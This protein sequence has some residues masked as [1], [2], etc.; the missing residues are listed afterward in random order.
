MITR[1]ISDQIEELYG[2]RCS[3]SFISDATDKV[4]QDIDEWQ[5]QM[6]DEIDPI[7]FI[8]TRHFSVKED[9]IVKKIAA[10]VILGY[11]MDG[12][13]SSISILEKTKVAKYWLGVW[14]RLKN[15]GGKT[16]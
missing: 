8:D 15:H 16:S 9:N 6:L 2:F 13:M 10:Y 5:K 1:H 4:L 12:K 14:N 3:E 7:V 11:S